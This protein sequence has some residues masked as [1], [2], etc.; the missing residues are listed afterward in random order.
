[1]N[2]LLAAL[3][4]LTL[5]LAGVGVLR[6]IWPWIGLQPRYAQLALG[7]CIGCAIPTGI[8]FTAYLVGVVFSRVL[9]LVPVLALAVYGAWICWRTT[10][11][12]TPRRAR[13]KMAVSMATGM[14]VLL[15]LALSW[16]RP[17]YGYDALS[18]WALKAKV[19]FYA[20]T[21]PPTL[22]DPQTTHHPEYPPL[23]PSA[24]AYVYFFLGRFDD[25]ASRVI[26]AAFYAAGGGVLWWWL[27]RMRVSMRDL[28]LLWW[29]AVPLTLEQ[30]KITYADLPLAVFL[31]V[32]FGAILCWLSDPRRREWLWLAAIFG[33]VAFWVK[34]DALIGVGSG[35]VALALVAGRRKLPGRPVGVIALTSAL[36]AAPWLLFIWWKGLRGDFGLPAGEIGRRFVLIVSELVDATFITGGF[37]FFWPVF[38]LTLAFGWRRLAKT[39]NL[40]L[41]VS[42]AVGLGTTVLVYLGTTLDLSA[43]LRTSADRV[44]LSLFVPALL[45]VALLWRTDFREFRSRKWSG[46][47]AVT[48]V[49]VAL[50]MFWV[51]LHRRGD[52]EI[53]GFTISPFPLALSWV[54]LATAVI[55]LARFAPISRRLRS[56]LVWR[57]TQYAV[58]VATFGLALVSI[59]YGAREVGELRRRFDGETLTQQHLATIDSRVREQ[60][61][62]ARQQWPDGTHVRVRPKRSLLYHQFYYE[63]FPSLIVD[64]SAGHEVRFDSAR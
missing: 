35:C 58:A 24:Q 34:E 39:E 5:A 19:T 17:V 64:D 52:E 50:G 26:F 22:F 28:W 42:T 6:I 27:E 3:A 63:A 47:I 10:N 45:V 13:V 36:I 33:G 25:V 20:R 54:W 55:T 21:W 8:F 11:G 31:M 61:D 37:A 60:L 38:V 1:M 32:F 15:A 4:A 40:W 57:V 62:A 7:Y 29:Y 14:L 53:A 56:A 16:S 23:V 12:Q 46:S 30:V 48:V 49:V 43:Q 9:I 2:L 59:G 18:I 44:L 41:V 51:G